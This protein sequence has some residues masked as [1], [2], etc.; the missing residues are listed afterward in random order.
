MYLNTAEHSDTLLKGMNRD[1]CT[2]FVMV[3]LSNTV[4]KR[5]NPYTLAYSCEMLFPW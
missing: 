2:I 5:K 1:S 3:L 4:K